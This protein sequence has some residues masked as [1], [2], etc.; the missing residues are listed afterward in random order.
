MTKE[1]KRQ[2]DREKSIMFIQRFHTHTE[3]ERDRNRMRTY[4]RIRTYPVFLSLFGTD[5]S[6]LTLLVLF[7]AWRDSIH[8]HVEQF[9]WFDEHHNMRNVFEYVQKH[10]MFAPVWAQFF[11][12]VRA[13]VE[14]A[15]HVQIQA[16]EIRTHRTV[17]FL[18]Y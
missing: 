8:G 3:R 13:C 9:L 2:K 12:R 1:K 11:V 7:G 14:D 10:F 18:I 16:I 15:I 4:M 6:S 5:K 17:N